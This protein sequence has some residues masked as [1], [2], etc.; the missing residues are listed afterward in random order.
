MLVGSVRIFSVVCPGVVLILGP[1]LQ[2]G[3]VLVPSA[4]PVKIFSLCNKTLVLMNVEG[5]TCLS[6]CRSAPKGVP[7]FLSLF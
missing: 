7:R 6:C 1:V 3:L 4:D 2:A 5:S